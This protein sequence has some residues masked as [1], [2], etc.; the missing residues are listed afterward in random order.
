VGEDGIQLLLISDWGMRHT[1]LVRVE[2]GAGQGDTFCV[3][4]DAFIVFAS[5]SLGKTTTNN[6]S[7]K[8]PELWGLEQNQLPSNGLK[9]EKC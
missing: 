9:T 3:D 2:D 8:R 7:H 1:L 5:P 6:F 4:L